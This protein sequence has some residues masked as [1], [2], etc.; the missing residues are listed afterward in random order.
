MI[1]LTCE[2][3]KTTTKITKQKQTHG[4]RDQAGGC[5]RGGRRGL[6]VVGEGD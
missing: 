5:Q 1:F 2:I 6:S 3:L 4:Y